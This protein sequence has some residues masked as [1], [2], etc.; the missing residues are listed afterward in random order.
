[1]LL[2]I[3]AQWEKDF[4]GEQWKG[5]TGLTISLWHHQF[6]PSILDFYATHPSSLKH[7]S[8]HMN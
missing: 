3:L 7:S 4:L 6:P 8:K 5:A 2:Q 1:M